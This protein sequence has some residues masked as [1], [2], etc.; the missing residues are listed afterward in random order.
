MPD[1]DLDPYD[2]SLSQDNDFS[3]SANAKFKSC[4]IYL[5]VYRLGENG[6]SHSGGSSQSVL[7]PRAHS[8]LATIAACHCVTSVNTDGQFH[9][10][11][12]M[13]QKNKTSFSAHF[14][15]V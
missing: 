2:F 6:V 15:F 9:V 11:M 5:R 10:T 14:V 1:S 8:G 12:D 3:G 13:V 7:G 4:I